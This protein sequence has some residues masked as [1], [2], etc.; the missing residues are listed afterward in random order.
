MIAYWHLDICFLFDDRA[1]D[2][3]L[4]GPAARQAEK[5]SIFQKYNMILTRGKASMLFVSSSTFFS[6]SIPLG[7]LQGWNEWKKRERS[8]LNRRK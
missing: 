8:I 7:D 2:R 4:G 6:P 5:K 3:P 1:T